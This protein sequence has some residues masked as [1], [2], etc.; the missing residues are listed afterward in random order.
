MAFVVQD[1]GAYGRAEQ[2]PQEGC[3]HEEYR[4]QPIR[5][6]LGFDCIPTPK[7]WIPGTAHERSLF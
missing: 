7:C 4:V 1:R 3:D 6:L 2:P 5:K